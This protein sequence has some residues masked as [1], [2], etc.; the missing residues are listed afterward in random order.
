MRLI[1]PFSARGRLLP[2]LLPALL[3]GCASVPHE[4]PVL[5]PLD[6]A[7]L[8]P[9][10]TPTPAPAA[11]LAADWWHA[12]GDPQL[13]R[14]MA[15]AFAHSPTLADA[16]ARIRA[17]RAVLAMEKG[18][19]A[20]Q[21]T[22]SAG[23]TQERFS[24]KYIYPA[25]YGGGWFWD[26]E[27]A[28]SLNW[29]LDLAGRQ[30]AMVA[31]VRAAGDALVLDAAAARVSLG[32]AVAEAYVNLARAER[33]LAIAREFTA[34]RTASLE[35]VRNRRTNQLASDLDVASAETLLAE[36]RQ[37]EIRAAGNRALMVHALAALAGHGADYYATIGAP[38]LQLEGAL[39][40]PQLLPA[41][42]L[43]R[44]P[45]ILAARANVAAARAGVRSAQAAF[46]PDV[47]LTAFVGASALGIGS[48][49]T[50]Q[51][52][53]AGA[54]PALSLPIFEGGALKG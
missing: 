28:V 11:P 47:N 2:V 54:G 8:G 38:T 40:V 16:E 22:G 49:F 14:I 48:L 6:E 30:K 24:A 3:A 18:P 32:G 13:D 46:Y 21:I 44:R 25:P 5:K 17:A 23:T 51:A 31:A 43:G 7:V 36:A 9:A 34:S 19:L 39:P 10:P 50:S 52:I 20:P 12:L 26:S 4:T 15:D 1:S 29:S 53:T 41:D 42:L 45:D 27:A 35:V 33:Q 37:A